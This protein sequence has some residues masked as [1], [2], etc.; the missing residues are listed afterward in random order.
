MR[1]RDLFHTTA[2]RMSMGYTLLVTL[3]VCVTLGSTY[4]LTRRVIQADVDL[5]ID[6]E[7]NSLE[8][9]YV[10]R[11]VPGLTDEVN[12]RID[13]WG[14]IGAVYLLASPHF[15]RLAG[16]VTNWPFDGAPTEP[17]PEF[18]IESIEPGQGSVHPVRAAVRRLANGDW[19]LVGTDMSQERRYARTF[20]SATLWGIGLSI[21]AAAAAGFSFSFR[22]ARRVG[23]VTDT[24]VRIM[25]GESGHRLPVGGT[26]DEFDA[27]AVSVN[28]VLDRLEEQTRTLR[29]TFDSVAHDLRAPLHRLRARMDALL[30]QPVL[31]PAVRE[32]V[33]SA[34]RDVDRLQRTLATLL[35]IALAESGAPLASPARVDVGELAG[36]LVELF[37]PVARERG[38]A[39]AGRADTGVIVEGNRQ[40]LAQL[41]SNLLENALKY[42][43][44]GGKIEVGVTRLRNGAQLAVSDNGPGMTPEERL[45]AG[46]PFARIGQ[47]SG[48]EGSGLGLSLAS[49]IARLHGARLTLESN[50]P[51]LRAVVDLP[52]AQVS[53]SRSISA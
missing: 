43:P 22:L 25:S 35:Q 38:L 30:R 20:R 9:Q 21:L 29:T 18:R 23:D 15:D 52:L 2:F 31:D 37:E 40:L 47:R 8:N 24:C 32:P 28:R 16:N 34:L 49:A 51:G 45:R 3:A 42:V 1:R 10:R 5:I 7:L 14:R 46:Q 13:S 12:L 19:L 36:E 26:S 27:L 41:I 53:L 48:V 4:F 39:L 11:G 44:A 50:E 17:W 33:E 6:T